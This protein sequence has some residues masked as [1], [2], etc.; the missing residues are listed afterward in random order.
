MKTVI[1]MLIAMI[2]IVL[3]LQN[4]VPLFGKTKT[5]EQLRI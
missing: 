5:A 4:V 2:L 1:L 3:E